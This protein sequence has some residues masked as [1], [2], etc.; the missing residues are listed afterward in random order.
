MSKI[1]FTVYD[2]FG[3][4]SSGFLLLMGISYA[5][6]GTFEHLH[7]S[8]ILSWVLLIIIV[9]ITGHILA[10]MS[11]WIL[12][13]II[14]NE[15]L[16]PPYINLFKKNSVKKCNKIF[17]PEYFVAFPARIIKDIT[18]IADGRT[19]KALYDYAY[20][21]AKSNKE[22]LEQLGI[23]LRLFGFCRNI[24]FTLF[25]LAI[26]FSA[27]RIFSYQFGSIS[28]IVI[29]FLG[30]I[31]MFIRYLKFLRHHSSELFLSLLELSNEEKGKNDSSY[32]GS[33]QIHLK[34]GNDKNNN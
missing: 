10:S 13:L 21:K 33:F 4:L 20:S 19:E 28:L 3:Y 17:F 34:K 1:P 25:I 22:M 30:S 9:Y 5:E 12:E 7:D 2:I 16:K 24:S 23:F 26:I 27:G 8:N 18:K 31:F 15:V 6:H 14:V 32:I 11:K 29:S